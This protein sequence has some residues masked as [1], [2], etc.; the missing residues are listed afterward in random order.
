MIHRSNGNTRSSIASAQVPAAAAFLYPLLFPLLASLLPFASP[1]RSSPPV[2]VLMTAASRLVT[3][4]L[5]WQGKKGCST[6]LQGIGRGSATPGQA[7]REFPDYVREIGGQRNKLLCWSAKKPKKEKHVPFDARPLSPLCDTSSSPRRYLNNPEMS[8]TTRRCR[9]S[10]L[11]WALL[12]GQILRN[13]FSC[14]QHLYI[15]GAT[16]APPRHS[17]CDD[18]TLGDFHS[19]RLDPGRNRQALP[20]LHPRR[21]P[22][23]AFG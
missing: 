4:P 17:V 9:R 18:T 21:Q 16:H 12:I 7:G 5:W 22:N 10:S 8:A 13:R 1:L 3:D 19:S 6:S 14:R 20:S 2:I 23:N 15:F 11:L